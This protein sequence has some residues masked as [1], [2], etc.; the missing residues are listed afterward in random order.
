ML[1]TFMYK[2]W[3]SDCL[4]V[5]NPANFM[6][7]FEYF[8]SIFDEKRPWKLKEA[9]FIYFLGNTTYLRVCG[10]LSAGIYVP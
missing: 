7:D 5:E 6:A 2:I 3:I 8:D 10:I 9:S 4:I 1:K